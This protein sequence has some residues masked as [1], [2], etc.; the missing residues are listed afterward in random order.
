ME[1]LDLC[2]KR[3]SVRCFTAVPISDEDRLYLME[4]ARWAATSGN[5]QARRFVI[6]EDPGRLKQ[7]AERASMQDFVADVGMLVFGVATD[8]DSRGAVADVFISMTQMEL[9]AVERGL[10][11]IWLGRFDREAIPGILAVP[12]GMEVVMALAVGHACEKGSAKE[13]LSVEELFA[14]DR[15]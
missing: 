4:A 5:R 10:G 11:T 6:I 2:R 13:K 14:V 1:V 12:E 15:F 8:A 7:V 3:H 9:A